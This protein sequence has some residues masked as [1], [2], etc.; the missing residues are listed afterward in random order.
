MRRKWSGDKSW[1]LRSEGR[2]IQLC[3]KMYLPLNCYYYK[4]PRY[5]ACIKE[6][7]MHLDTTHVHVFHCPSLAWSE[8]QLKYSSTFIHRSQRR[9]EYVE[10]L[11]SCEM[12]A[13]ACDLASKIYRQTW[14]VRNICAVVYYEKN[15]FQYVERI[16]GNLHATRLPIIPYTERWKRGDASWKWKN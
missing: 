8:I 13:F 14:S 12:N 5:S 1:G 16:D 9:C 10:L 7:G 3:F 6:T 2:V 15:G 4:R 11:S